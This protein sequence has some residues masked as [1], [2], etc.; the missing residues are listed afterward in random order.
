MT[1]IAIEL[2]GI[3][4]SFGAVKANEDVSMNIAK[5]SI[6]GIIGEN[7]AGKSTL[8]SI[9]YGYY[10]ADEGCIKVNGREARIR[11]SQEAIRLGI[12][13]VHQH[14]MLV[15]NFTVLENIVLGAEGG[16]KLAGGMA[17]AR[18]H[19]KTL[20]KDYSL[21]VDP[22][23]VVGELGVGLQQRVEILKA[24]YRGAD[25]LIL[26]EPTAV[27]TP[28][29]ADHLFCILN[30]LRD[31]G[32]TVIL[33]T[34]KLREVMDITDAVTVMRAGR[35]VGN[36][37][38]RD[39]SREIL[40]DMMVGR[41]VILKVDKA[42]A[43]AGDTVLDVKALGLVDERGVKLLKDLSFS[44]RAGEIV[45]VA[46]VSGN[47]QSELLEVLAGMKVPTSGSIVYKGEDLNR[48]RYRRPRA[49]EFR[50]LGIAHVP[51]DRSREGLVKAFPMY[52]NAILGYDDGPSFCKGPLFSRKALIERT[53]AFISE[54][55]IRPTDALLRVGLLSGGNQQK[56]VLAREIDANPDL[57]LIGQ[58]TRGVDIGAIEFIH[59]R[60]IQ[61]RDEGK[62][63]LLVSVELEEI[64]ALSDRILVM[65]GGA[66]S[67]EVAGEEATTSSLG[68]LMGGGAH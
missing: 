48:R 42:P 62:A 56:V 10:Q 36:V 40:A 61:L 8:M 59:K 15:D 18:E 51:E 50:K 34:H 66:I 38:T 19:L 39:V 1:D 65:T 49:A 68:L 33:I 29:E 24:L 53:R 30:A 17:A 57:L 27:L 37:Q 12:G 20:N 21:E 52:E 11:N 28:K 45:G 67:G 31:Q 43:R 23:A 3:S 35:V 9:L 47:G 2:I 26:D 16:L 22:D 55:D 25:V 60:L 13:M 7:G 64:L 5:G 63:I 46:G 32:K 58:P 54:F 44:V 6:H 41:K 4:K 14:F